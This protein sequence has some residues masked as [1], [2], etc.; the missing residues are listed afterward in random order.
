[1]SL[2]HLLVVFHSQTGR[3]E[4]LANAVIGGARAAASESVEV[5]VRRAKHADAEDLRWADALLLG[6]PEN[7]GYMSGAIKD[8][9]DR[10][11]YAVAGEKAALPYALFV[12]AGNDGTGAVRSIERI[13]GGYP[14][15][16]VQ[17]PIVVVG[18]VSRAQL[19]ECEQLG[20]ALA[21]GLEL[22]VF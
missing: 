3:T 14:L 11:F 8:F 16:E 5:R 21:A 17:A 6:T 12:S 10:T 19:D 2:K 4:Q 9:F 20:A 13:V 7:F 18:A 15:R 1:M 22:G